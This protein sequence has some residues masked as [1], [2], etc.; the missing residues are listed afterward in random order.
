[1]TSISTVQQLFE[2]YCSAHQQIAGFSWGP[3]IELSSTDRTLY[4]LLHIVPISSQSLSNV[5]NHTLSILCVDLV[6]SDDNEM[7]NDVWSD[8]Q[9]ILLDIKKF[10]QNTP[11]GLEWIALTGDPTLVPVLEDQKDRFSGWQMT[12]TVNVS[13]ASCPESAPVFDMSICASWPSQGFGGGATGP[14]GPQGDQGPQGPQGDQGLQGVQGTN[15]TIGIN[16]VQGPQGDQGPQGPQGTNGTIGINGVQGPQGDQ[17]PQGVQGGINIETYE[18]QI[19]F[20]GT[21]S[22]T[23]YK[24]ATNLS[25][26]GTVL[27]ITTISTSG[28][29]TLTGLIN[30]TPLGGSTNAV[31]VSEVTQTHSSANIFSIGDDINL[32]FSGTAGLNNVTVKIL[33]E[34]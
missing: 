11:P 8:T 15:G 29:G 33:Y 24:V 1:M 12:M 14:Q 10:F 23:S 4:P 19:L 5:T 32:T 9:Q 2:N 25:F 26:S 22:N 16:G 31:S 17:G 28:T 27:E 13:E 34:R 30:A 18:W 20:Y 6:R 3:T 21:L 7:L